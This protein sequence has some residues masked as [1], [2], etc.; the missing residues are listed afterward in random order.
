MKIIT[1]IFW[2][3]HGKIF[4]DK[5]VHYIDN[6]H[7]DFIDYPFS[8]FEM[9]ENISKNMFPQADFATY[10]RGRLLYCV[11]EKKYY[12]YLD[13]CITKQQAQQLVLFYDLPQEDVLILSDEHYSCDRCCAKKLRKNKR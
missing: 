1:G 11:R 10:P 7:K 3:V 4:A 6:T 2:V 13:S 12:L 5:Y 8:H 9:W